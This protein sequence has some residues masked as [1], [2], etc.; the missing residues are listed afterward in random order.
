MMEIE[1]YLS[2]EVYNSSVHQS[3]LSKPPH[4][5]NAEVDL[6]LFHPCF[7]QAMASPFQLEIIKFNRDR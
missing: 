4:A 5:F 3:F 6:L 7:H 2:R 1:S